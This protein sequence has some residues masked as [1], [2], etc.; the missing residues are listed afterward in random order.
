MQLDGRRGGAFRRDGRQTDRQ[1][2]R[3]TDAVRWEERRT[4]LDGNFK[5]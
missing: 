5:T 4:Q 3:R 1:E 2:D